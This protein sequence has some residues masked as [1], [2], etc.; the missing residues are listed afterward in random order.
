MALGLLY[1]RDNAEQ[2]SDNTYEKVQ[3]F[4]REFEKEFM[5]INCVELI[6]LDLGKEKERMVFHEKGMME[7]CRRFTGRAAGLIA[8]IVNSDQENKN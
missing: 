4:L 2:S 1:G 5:S 8:E 7:E 6:G 3:R